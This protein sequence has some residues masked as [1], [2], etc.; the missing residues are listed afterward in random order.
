MKR[1]SLCSGVLL[2]SSS[3]L[4]ATR[5]ILGAEGQTNAVPHLDISLSGQ[6]GSELVLSGAPAQSYKVEAT[7]DFLSWTNWSIQVT[8][9]SGTVRTPAP[10]S[11]NRLFFRA[12]RLEKSS[13]LSPEAQAG[14]RLF[15]ETRFAQFFFAHS[16]GDIN[17]SLSAGDP[18]LD[19]SVTLTIAVP[20]PFAGQ[21]MN[22]RV[23]HLFDEQNAN[24]GYRAYADFAI[25]SPIPDRGDGRKTTIRNSPPLANA[26]IPR[27]GGFFLHFDGE[28]PDGVSLVKGT[29]TGRNFGW[30]ASER[31]QALGHIAK[32]IR[33]DDGSQFNGPRFGGAY[34]SVLSGDVGI[35]DAFRLPAEYRLDVVKASDEQILETIGKLVDA[36]LK[37]LRFPLDSSGE[38]EGSAYDLFLK[39]NTL[40]RKP[41]P[42][43]TDIAYSRRLRGLLANLTFPA[44]VTADEGVFQS[45]TQSFTF[46]AKELTG[47]KMF[48]A[49]PDASTTVETG[50]AGN[51]ITCHAAPHFTDFDFHNTGATQWEYDAIHGEGAFAK[52]EIPTLS[53][54][55]AASNDFLPPTVIHPNAKGRFLTVPS[56]GAPGFVD[57]GL[58]NIYANADYPASE[59]GL[60]NLLNKRFPGQSREA[61]LANTV[62][63]FKTPG[64]RDLSQSAPYMHTGQSSTI[65]SLLFFYRFTSDLAR[66]GSARNVD[67]EI[68]RIFLTKEDAPAVAAFLRSLNQDLPAE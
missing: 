38:Y 1:F 9:S 17:K 28:F 62:A 66:E 3:A 40:P 47:L 58:W 45:L 49:E 51:C 52:I 43:E 42:S 34:R 2:G 13:P 5:A 64:L 68:G 57:L 21:S 67:P 27:P 29:L 59:A 39:K 26:S 30:L 4:L 50:K 22:C 37:E 55:E 32:V 7:R 41:A 15:L 48:L 11:L 8:D 53:Q 18:V 24:G 16:N 33:E 65:E 6:M 61:V 12:S 63:L 36:Y 60:E 20:G 23:C 54:R 25:R 35:S 10:L 56:K 31:G 46:G 44:F 14:K 19:Q